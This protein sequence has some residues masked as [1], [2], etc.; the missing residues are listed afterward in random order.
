MGKV[1]LDSGF[2]AGGVIISHFLIYLLI[3]Q[4][5]PIDCPCGF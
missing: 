3:M 4:L 5:T 2:N 1:S